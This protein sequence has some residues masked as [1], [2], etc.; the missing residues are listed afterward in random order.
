MGWFRVLPKPHGYSRAGFTPAPNASGTEKGSCGDVAGLEEMWAFRL[1]CFSLACS[2]PHFLHL[3][4]EET[5]SRW[6]TF[7]PVSVWKTKTVADTG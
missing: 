5:T 4:T 1:H 3:Y 7:K 2:E 6:L